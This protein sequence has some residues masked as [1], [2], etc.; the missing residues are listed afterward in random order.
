MD[1]KA[2]EDRLNK[3]ELNC[4]GLPYSSVAILCNLYGT[5]HGVI[6]SYICFD[7]V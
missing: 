7:L 6:W 4:L 5:V 2:I 1:C 3:Q